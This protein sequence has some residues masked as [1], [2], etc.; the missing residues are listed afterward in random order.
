MNQPMQA[1]RARIAYLGSSTATDGGAELRLLH[2]ARKM[3][4]EFEVTLFLPDQGPLFEVARAQGIS[5]MNLEFLRLR[6]HRGMGWIR[7]W[8]SVRR[9]RRRFAEELVTRKVELVHFND[10]IDLP[11]YSVPRRLGI[12]ALSHLR[13]ILADPTAKAFYRRLARQSRIRVLPVSAAVA[14]A[15]LPNDKSIPHQVLYDPSPDRTLFRPCTEELHEERRMLRANFGWG[16]RDFVVGMVS[17]LLEAK[18][19]LNFLSVAERL[20]QL[21]PTG[22]R[23]LMVAGPSP[24]RDRYRREVLERGQSLAKGS[25]QWV[26]GA[27]HEEVPSLLRVSDCFLHLP[28]TED[29][30]P[31]VVLEAMACGLPVVSWRSGGV[32]EELED[33]RAGVLLEA[34]DLEGVVEGV[35]RLRADTNFRDEVVQRALVRLDT[36]FSEEAHFDLLRVVYRN[37]LEQAPPRW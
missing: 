37:A 7:W 1:A 3:R 10:L 23:F 36:T 2:M 20:E 25:F 5:V 28:D 19:H 16:E 27:P 21:G 18:G 32:P 15:M 11:F 6:R 26:P 33:G 30:L 24:G 9:A 13:F 12:P 35:R 22:F 4:A 17:K 8:K 34:G 14:K 31:G 29:S